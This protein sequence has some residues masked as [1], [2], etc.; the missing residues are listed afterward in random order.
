MGWWGK[1]VG[2]AVGF[3]IG[4]PIGAL[5]GI[6]IGSNFGNAGRGFAGIGGPQMAR[7]EQERVQMAFFTATFSIMGAVA[8]ADG[9]VTKDE[10]SLAEDVMRQMNLNGEMRQAAMRL[11]IKGKQDDF[12]LE[13]VLMQFRQE[14][15]RRSN[16]IRMFIEIQIQAA[17]ADGDLHPAE[18]RMLLSMCEMLGFHEQV[19]RQIEA[20]VK[21]SM[22][23]GGGHYQQS[24][25][26][27]QASSALTRAEA[28]AIL[29]ITPQSTGADIKKAYRRL[30]SQHHPDK[31]VSK[32]L[33]EEM[34]KLATEKSQKIR[35]AYELLKA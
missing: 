33:P 35:D 25:S 15:H 22:G 5:L 14:C 21:S 1:I 29:G 32:G 19:Y 6:A 28:Y 27:S 17:Y 26:R 7:G 9:K 13:D 12:P 10:I 8:K 30:M 23:Q 16:L 2:G 18:D 4:G 31:L 34:M 3:M 11:F 24:G 20:M